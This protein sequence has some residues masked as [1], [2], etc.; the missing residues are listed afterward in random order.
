MRICDR[1]RGAGA[2]GVLEPV[3]NE[4]GDYGLRI[5]NPD[6]SQAEKSGNGLRIF[7]RYL[8][9]HCGAPANFTVELPNES[10]QCSVHSDGR[11]SVDM[12]CAQFD[13]SENLTRDRVWL[14]PLTVGGVDLRCC[15]VSVGNPHCVVP[16]E[17][18]TDLDGLDWLSWGAIIENHKWFPNR[19]N[20]QFLKPIDENTI[21]IRVWERGAGK[22]QASG[23]SAVA[24]FAVARRLNWISARASV[25]MP[26]GSLDVE[27]TPSGRLYQTGPVVEIGEFYLRSAE[28]YRESS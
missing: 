22:T 16:F 18:E 27:E 28:L 20:V 9:D 3:A 24:A 25:R 7:A 21:E 15:A 6:G 13:P 5:W 1:H 11:V 8:Y 26:G 4:A 2:D 19:T 17:T 10:A 14:R 12:G 23:S